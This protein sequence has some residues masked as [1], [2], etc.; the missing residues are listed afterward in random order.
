[1]LQVFFRPGV[2]SQLEAT[3][4]EKLTGIVTQFQALCRGHLGRK[5]TEKLRV[6]R[7]CS[8]CLSVCLSL[9]LTL[10]NVHTHTHT[11]TLTLTNAH[12]HSDHSN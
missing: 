10:T 11:F 9:S 2:L 3:R 4:D 12:D 7:L 5:K 8:V 6:G 1:M